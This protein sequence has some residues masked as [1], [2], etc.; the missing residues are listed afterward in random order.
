MI[1]K[2]KVKEGILFRLNLTSTFS[3]ST[4]GTSIQYYGF[5]ELFSGLWLDNVNSY[6]ALETDI[7]ETTMQL[8]IFD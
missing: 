7:S 8:D 6:D 2:V 3:L 5:I 4:G 1:T